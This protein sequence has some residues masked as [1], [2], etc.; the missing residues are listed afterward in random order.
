[1]FLINDLKMKNFVFVIIFMLILIACNKKQEQVL[2]E[3][4]KISKVFVKE[5]FNKFFVKFNKDS[6]F[7]LHRIV[8][9]LKNEIYNSDSGDY[10]NLSIKKE[11]WKFFNSFSLSKKY[12][13]NINKKDQDEILLNIQIVDSGVNVDYIFTIIKG[14]WFLIKIVDSST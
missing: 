12:I 4:K 3:K 6:V 7:Q 10:N 11:E 13:K 2:L 8:F 14:Q 9:P 1:M 5:D